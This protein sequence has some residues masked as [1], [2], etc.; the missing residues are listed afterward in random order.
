MNIP[1]QDAF[2]P[3]RD[4]D[5]TMRLPG[6]YRERSAVRQAYIERYGLTWASYLDLVVSIERRIA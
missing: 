5:A 4:A 2:I 6:T 1:M 3:L